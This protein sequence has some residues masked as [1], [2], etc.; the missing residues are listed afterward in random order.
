[1]TFCADLHVHSRHSR[2]C[3]R[4]C[5][6]HHLAWWAARKGIGVVGTGDFTHPAWAQEL[7]D[8]LVPAEPG[9]FRLRD[10]V[11]RDVLCRLPPSCRTP[12]RFLLS[13]EISTIYKRG[14]RTRKVHHLLYAPDLDA[15][16]E[17]TRRLAR[18]GN[19]DADGR[20]ILGLDSRDL[21]E[22][23]LE[24]GEGCYLVPAHVW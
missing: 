18:V 7:R 3:S 14:D 12:V 6:L 13:T 8:Q 20:P 23:T 9:L 10:E 22:I 1:M 16:A 11:E 19:L 4:D 17:I 24:S 5:D 2:A 21:L 15:V